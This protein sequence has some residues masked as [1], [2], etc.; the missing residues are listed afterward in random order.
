MRST[1]WSG[2][3]MV[4]S[5]SISSNVQVSTSEWMR[6]REPMG[7]WCW[8][9]VQT[10]RFSSSSLSKTMVLHFGHLV[11]R[12]SG[13]SRFLDLDASRGFLA[14]VVGALGGGGGVTAGSVVSR[15]SD[16]LVNEVVAIAHE[17]KLSGGGVQAGVRASACS[18]EQA[19]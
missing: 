11:H 4:M 19:E 6:S 14:N 7:K 13:I 18:G 10:L 12:P 1:N 15:P 17:F 3:T 9:C 16:F 5:A 8:H 2:S